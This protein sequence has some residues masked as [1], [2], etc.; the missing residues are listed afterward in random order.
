M[1]LFFNFIYHQVE[2]FPTV[3][4]RENPL[5]YQYFFW[6]HGRLVHHGSLPSVFCHVA[7][8]SYAVEF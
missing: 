4:D 8:N 6:M 2:P 3:H 7:Y 5:G 1:Y